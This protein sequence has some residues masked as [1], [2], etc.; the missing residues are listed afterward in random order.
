MSIRRTILACLLFAAY[1]S[2]D[3]RA[4]VITVNTFADENNIDGDCSLREAVAAANGDAAVD[5]CS[6]VGAFGDDTINLPA[7]TYDLSTVGT[8]ID[9]N[10]ATSGNGNALILFGVAGAANTM[11]QANAAADTAT[12]RLFAVAAGSA[13]FQGLTLRH[14]AGTG[15]GA[16]IFFNSTNSSTLTIEDCAVT[17][18]RTSGDGGAMHVT[19]NPY[20]I[21]IDSSQF[22]GNRA[23]GSGANGG[24][25]NCL[26]SSGSSLSVTDSTF[27]DNRGKGGGGAFKIGQNVTSATFT[28]NT[29][30]NNLV[31]GSGSDGGAI[32]TQ[33][34]AIQIVDCTF[35]NNQARDEGGALRIGSGAATT[36]ISGCTFS[37]NKV[38]SG[39]G[40]D[41]GAI[42]EL[43]SDVTVTN[44]TFFGNEANNDGGAIHKGGTGT[45][46][47]NNVTITSN[48]ADKDTNNNGDGGGIRRGNGTIHIGN[49]IVAKNTDGSVTTKHPDCSTGNAAGVVTQGY[50]FIGVGDLGGCTTFVDAAN[51][52]K[53]GTDAS[54]NDPMLQA[55]LTNNGGNTL[56]L[57]PLMGSQVIDMGNPALPLDGGLSGGLRRCVGSDQTGDPRPTGVACDIGAVE[58]AAETP[59]PTRT[60]TDTPT[61]T[62][63]ETPTSTPSETPTETAT[64]T[65]TSTSTLTA[66][67]TATSTPTST[68][69]QTP[70][71]TATATPTDTPTTTPTSTATHTPTSTPTHS[72]TN[73]PTA[74]ATSTPTHTVT[75]TPTL[76]A[77]ATPTRTPT[78]TATQTATRTP[79]NTPTSTPPPTTSPTTTP[80]RTVAPAEN[81]GGNQFC[82][83][84]IDNDGDLRIDCADSDCALVGFCVHTVPVAQANGSVLLIALL[85]A[86]GVFGISLLRG[87]RH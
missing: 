45:L 33:G 54:P 69:T 86:V 29:F 57:A 75:L 66:T 82:R 62:P 9:I 83:D 3:V 56:T 51:G 20:S 50:N 6:G 30:T 67:E 26:G 77:T 10:D 63:T 58:L 5:A 13:T 40:G 24:A 38:I 71:H 2:D 80:T 53:E 68:P 43:S 34:D 81:S 12:F 48:T 25:V 41:G 52:D 18:N 32:S 36:T 44:S 1:A 79:T 31:D 61:S 74:T 37:N 8:Q 19:Q 11:V 27:D 7:G 4:A 17:D 14:G 64:S 15:N 87:A 21:V 76:S 35:D 72:P 55:T 42:R 78:L 65:P 16:A 39:T 49:S 73:T 23:T 60:A 59:T 28:R 46:V 70:T 84:G 47:L 22:T 85:T